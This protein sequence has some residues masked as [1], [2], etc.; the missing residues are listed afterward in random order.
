V[1]EAGILRVVAATADPN[2]V[3]DGAGLRQLRDA[4]LEVA[5][6][7]LETEARELIAGFAKHVRTGLPFVTLKMAATLDGKVAARDGSSRWITGDPARRDVHLLRAAS[8]A[9]LVGAGTAAADRPSLGVR[10]DGYRGRQP[11]RIVLDATGRRGAPSAPDGPHGSTVVATVP[12]VL[13]DARAAWEES[14]AEVLV[15]EE[16]DD[17]GMVSLPALMEA[18]GKRGIQSV[19]IEGGPTVAWSAVRSGIV[20][21]FVLYLAPKLMGGRDAPGILGG[22]GVPGVG[23]ALPVKIVRVERL[24][25]DIKVVADVHRDR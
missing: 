5:V 6:G 25:D 21:R 4:G 13:R 2:P 18:L 23:D 3:V 15:I 10:L 16:S 20:D 7:E 14:G 9:V 19:L 22:G 1:A 12:S 11:L 8:D 24:G 17:D